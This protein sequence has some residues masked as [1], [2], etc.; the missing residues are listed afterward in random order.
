M[1]NKV[2]YAES[3][4]VRMES[5]TIKKNGV[6][7]TSRANLLIFVLFLSCM[8]VYAKDIITLQNGDEIKAKVTEISSS[9]IKYKR[10]ENLD[11][12]TIVIPR[13]NVF[14]ITYHFNEI[15]KI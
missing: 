5:E 6:S 8:S 1:I 12:P 15:L 11:G 13:A 2:F 3:S 9:E 4:N 7:W 10:F 14:F